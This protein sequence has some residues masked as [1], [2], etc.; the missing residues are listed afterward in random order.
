MSQKCQT[1]KTRLPLISNDALAG[2]RT[3][4]V[5]GLAFEGGGERETVQPFYL[6]G[7]G[8]QRPVMR[9]RGA[10]DDEA[11]ARQRLERR[12]DIAVGIGIM[13]PGEAAAQRWGC[14]FRR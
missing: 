4:N 1:R 2:V 12:G 7:S 8:G 6:G 10:V 11:S 9:L 3:G 5:G 13:R 14:A